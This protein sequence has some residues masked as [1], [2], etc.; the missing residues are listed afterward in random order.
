METKQQMNIDPI[1]LVG[2]LMLNVSENLTFLKKSILDGNLK[3]D[4]LINGISEFQIY[5]ADN[6]VIIRRAMMSMMQ[7]QAAT[8]RPSVIA[9]TPGPNSLMEYTTE[10]QVK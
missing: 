1:K 6:L 4:Q 7:E 2:D 5:L 8:Q 3:A 9:H 10:K